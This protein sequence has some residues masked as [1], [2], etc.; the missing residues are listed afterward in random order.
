MIVLKFCCRCVKISVLTVK[1][2]FSESNI[3]F[4]ELGP[5]SWKHSSVSFHR[6]LVRFLRNC[7]CP[8]SCL[9][10]FF[11]ENQMNLGKTLIRLCKSL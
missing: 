2:K 10:R 8:R 6:I 11:R 7:N 4:P 1:F 3:Q 9:K 5:F